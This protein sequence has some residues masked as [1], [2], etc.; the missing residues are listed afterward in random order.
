[1]KMRR[2]QIF[3]HT[4]Y[5]LL[6]KFYAHKRGKAFYAIYYCLNIHVTVYRQRN[7]MLIVAITTND[8]NFFFADSHILWNMLQN[9]HLVY[10][11]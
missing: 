11:I 10:I 7:H 5:I 1:M 2:R 4:N 8:V 3:E 9:C 6:V